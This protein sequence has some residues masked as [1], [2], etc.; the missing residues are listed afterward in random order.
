MPHAIGAGI[1]LIEVQ[2][3]EDLSILLEWQD[4]AIDGPADGHLGIGFRAAL[5]ATDTRAWTS[6]QIS[7]LVVRGG[8]SGHTLADSS[9]EYFRASR[10]DVSAPTTFA[11]GFSV[12]VVLSGTGMVTAS[13]P[14]SQAIPLSAGDTLLLAHA[15][16]EFTVDG[17]LAVLRCQPPET[18]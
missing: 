18:R 7:A 12:L 13:A 3:P 17:N 1:F 9:A 4:Y 14:E 5:D 8:V 2:Q 16:G 11:A 15:L 10:V 6:A